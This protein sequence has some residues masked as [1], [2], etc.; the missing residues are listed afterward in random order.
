MA[1]LILILV[2]SGV[3]IL[4]V[5]KPV[6]GMVASV[7]PTQHIRYKWGK[8][9]IKKQIRKAIEELDYDEFVD[10]FDK[11][12]TFDNNNGS[13]KRS[14]YKKDW[15]INNDIINSKKLFKIRF[16]PALLVEQCTN[17][18][19][20]SDELI[21]M[22]QELI[23]KEKTLQQYE[24]FDAIRA[25]EEQLIQKEKDLNEKEEE[26]REIIKNIAKL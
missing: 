20:S 18:T 11:I 1:E 17:S 12:Q 22:E 4:A 16:N 2:G 15:C 23:K 10:A 9:K 19:T 14:K 13:Q 7:R 5:G 8:R 24:G 26:I 25:K 21:E 6:F 3:G